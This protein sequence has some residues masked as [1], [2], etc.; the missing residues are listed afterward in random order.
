MERVGIGG[1][2]ESEHLKDGEKEEGIG[3]GRDND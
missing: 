2:K 3:R 1:R